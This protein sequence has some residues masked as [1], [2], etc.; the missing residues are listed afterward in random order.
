[1]TVIE[2]SPYVRKTLSY[3]A[4]YR[5]ASHRMHPRL[6]AL[7]LQEPHY[8]INQTDTL[9]LSKDMTQEQVQEFRRGLTEA[10]EEGQDSEEE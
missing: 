5:M 2:I 4:G 6:K 10:L 7:E 1:M 9:V 3:L 8:Y